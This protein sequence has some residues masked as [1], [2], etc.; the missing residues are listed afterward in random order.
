MTVKTLAG[1]GLVLSCVVAPGGAA[2]EITAREAAAIKETAQASMDRWRAPGLVLMAMRDG[3][4]PYVVALGVSD[5]ETGV[6]MRADMAVSVASVTKVVTAVTAVTLAREGLIDLERPIGQYLPDLPPRL[7]AVTMEQLLSHTAGLGEGTPPVA[8]TLNGGLAPVCTAMNDD[9]FVADPGR[10]WG[11][12]NMGFTLAGCVLEVVGE[13]P[14]PLVVAEHVL[15]PLGMIHSTFDPLEAMTWAHAQGHDTRGGQP[16]VVRPYNSVPNIA[17]AGQ[18]ITTVGDLARLARALLQDGL[19]EG[20]QALPQRVLRE[21]AR[22]RGSGGPL[23]AEMPSYG[24]GLHLRSV[25]GLEILE[26]AGTLA[27]FGASFALAPQQGLAAVAATNG[28]Y[29]AP[30]LGTQNA[31]E[32]LAGRAPSS[33]DD[34]LVPISAG[35]SAAAL[36][37][38]TALSDTLAI[39]AVEGRLTLERTGRNYPLAGRPFG[40]LTIPEYPPYLP[41]NQTPL[42]LVRDSGGKVSFIRIGWR[43]YRRVDG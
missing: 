28:R 12:T 20:V 33:L 15:T 29:S 16:Q 41:L 38:Y 11:Y 27:G 23:F 32:V 9:A 42:E 35:D 5:V 17:P 36:G 26:H 22:P 7:S 43:L 8:P 39:K 19:L 2:Q 18:L 10:A 40:Y 37:R 1:I 4:A 14:F 24:L 6:P 30:M 3:A 21:M 31:L 25:E 34:R 13:K